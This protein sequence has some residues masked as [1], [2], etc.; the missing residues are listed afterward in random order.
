[1]SY[2]E[3]TTPAVCEKCL[4]DNPYVEM[5]RERNG[6]Q[7]KICTRPFTVFRWAPKKGGRLKKTVICLTCARAKNCCQCCMLDLSLGIDLQTRDQLL[8]MAGGTNTGILPES[9][10]HDARNQVSRI[11]NAN[12]LDRKFK[13]EDEKGAMVSSGE[14]A[15]LLLAKISEL[16]DGKKQRPEKSK[17][18]RAT[19]DKKGAKM[20]KKELLR[21]CKG[22]PFKS[23]LYEPPQNA[24]IRSFFLF[25]VSDQVA[26]YD[27]EEYFGSILEQGDSRQK[28]VEAVFLNSRARF[29]YVKFSSR[30]IAE[31]MAS[32]V[33]KRYAQIREKAADS[34]YRKPC[35]IVVRN[36]VP[37]RVCWASS[38]AN[39]G[40]D[41][42]N[43]ELDAISG[44]V[45]MQ[46]VRLAREDEKP[47]K[48]KGDEGNSKEKGSARMAKKRRVPKKGGEK[49]VYKTLSSSFEL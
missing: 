30:E 16:T 41:Y 18:R 25:G 20:S 33:F 24:E 32:E 13:R 28:I 37:V 4:G 9:V 46:M 15:K 48:R 49:L 12:Q 45:M 42:S 35:V 19:Q 39:T 38:A 11:Y 8:K 6:A 1:M 2:N 26:N 44:V 7:C 29:G 23:G 21:L 31:K 47:G 17:K 14:R 27:I 22:L 3:D 36:D 40:V 43:K 10:V 5:T 34:E